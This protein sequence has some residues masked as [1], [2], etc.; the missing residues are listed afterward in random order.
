MQELAILL[1]AGVLQAHELQQ[2]RAPR[3]D[4]GAAREEV[5]AHH[6][7]QHGALARA[8]RTHVEGKGLQHIGSKVL[9]AKADPYFSS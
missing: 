4:A 2:Q 3:D 7:L 6:R 9:T 1:R 8:L 5:L